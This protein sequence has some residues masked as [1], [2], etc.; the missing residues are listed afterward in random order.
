MP[1]ESIK[2]HPERGSWKLKFIDRYVGIP[3]VYVLG[4]CRGRRRE[5][6]AS[7][8]RIALLK[9]AGIGDTIILSGA[10][11][12]IRKQLPDAKITLVCGRN[13]LETAELIR[14]IDTIVALNIG[15]IFE[16]IGKIRRLGYFDAWLDFGPW[17]R[18]NGIISHFAPARYKVG[19][20]TRGQYRHYVYDKFVDHIDHVPNF[21]ELMNYRNII[22]EIGVAGESLPQ[23]E[24]ENGDV[25]GADRRIAI[26]IFP[27][28]SRSYLK[29]WPQAYWIGLI[30]RLTDKNYDLFLTGGDNDVEGLEKI[31][32]EVKD[33]DRVS[34]V[35][36]KYS[37][38]ETASLL[39]ASR[40]VISVD[41]GTMHLASAMNCNLI[42]IHGPTSPERWGPLG[43]NSTPIK[44]GLA[45]AP[46]IDFGFDSDC[47]DNVCMH[48]ITPD[49]VIDECKKIIQA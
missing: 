25:R 31:R 14:G 42:S 9:T 48:S 41:T 24:V 7:I 20:R 12:D 21:H 11:R 18:F 40:L 6:P 36:G 10:I 28:G 1:F 22:R 13:N 26:H 43:S 49:T 27:G 16:C 45:C 2:K 35:A 46:C 15:N 23:I 47:G 39:K 37:L 32:R 8:K 17:P 3:M 33:P 44:T 5:K 19:F 34:I 38:R 29:E 4:L 30:N